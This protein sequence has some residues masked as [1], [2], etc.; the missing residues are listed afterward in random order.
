MP[1]GPIGEQEIAN[2]EHIAPQKTGDNIAAKKV[3]PYVFG[4]DSQW[5]RPPA[6]LI[7][8]AYDYVGFSNPDANDNYQT[9]IFN[10]GGSGGTLVRTISLT[11][12]GS[13]NVTSITRT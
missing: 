1:E 6:P 8:A 10:S 4:T 3:V 7:D 5:H 2:R 13:S 9:L 12:D 11:Y